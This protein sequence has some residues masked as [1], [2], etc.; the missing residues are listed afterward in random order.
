MLP[1]GPPKEAQELL[2]VTRPL[3]GGSPEVEKLLGVRF[4]PMT[5][6]PRPSYLH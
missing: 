3:G 2:R 1:V 5:S 6:A 4:V